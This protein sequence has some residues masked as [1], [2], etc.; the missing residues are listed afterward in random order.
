MSAGVGSLA[1][2]L[3]SAVQDDRGE[4][5]GPA[6]WAAGALESLDIVR[7]DGPHRADFGPVQPLPGQESPHV[8]LRRV[9]LRGGFGNRK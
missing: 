5:P 1:R 3:R 6:G 8:G 4:L 2:H 7:K 9:E